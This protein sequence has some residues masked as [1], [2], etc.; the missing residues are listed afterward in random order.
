MTDLKSNN[1]FDSLEAFF[2]ERLKDASFAPPQGPWAQIEEELDLLEKQKRKRRFLWFFMSGLVL[3]CGL[4][5]LWFFVLSDKFTPGS[6]AE[7][8][9][10]AL[11]VEEKKLNEEKNT[12]NT[13]NKNTTTETPGTIKEEKTETPNALAE[14]KATEKTVLSEN[15]PATVISQSNKIQLA[16]CTKKA[17]PAIFNKIPYKVIEVQGNDGYIR[18]FA[19]TSGNKEVALNIIHN[20]GFVKAF[21][22][23]NFNSNDESSVVK[24]EGVI[25]K[26]S[27]IYTATTASLPKIKPVSA[28]EQNSTNVASVKNIAETKTTNAKTEKNTTKTTQPAN[29][30]VVTNSAPVKTENN[31]STPPVNLNN[32]SNNNSAN[33]NAL[34]APS[35]NQNTNNTTPPVAKTEEVK[36]VPSENTTKTDSVPTQ[37]VANE[38]KADSTPVK[39]N[40]VDSVAKPASNYQTPDAFTPEWAILLLAGPNI[41]AQNSQSNL[42]VATNEQQT[43]SVNAEAKIQFKPFK[44]FSFSAGVNYNQLIANQGNPV[45]FVFNKNQ[46]DDYIFYSSHGP[47]A[48]PMSVLLEGYNMGVP[49]D[50]FFAKYT[51][52][53]KLNVISIPLEAN[54]H[55]LNKSKFSL[56]AG[57]GVNT[58]F[59]LSQRTKLTIVKENFNNDIS[60]NNITVNKFNISMLFSLGCDIRLGKRLYL[61]LVPS[62]RYGITN[63][64]ATSGTTFSPAYFSG[65]AGLKFKF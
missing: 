55:F 59:V 12:T 24:N 41:F 4:A 64:S 6:L 48:A 49:F 23:K 25:E 51:Y 14:S 65:N 44:K 2:H 60:Y 31:N 61:T 57:V 63:M 47:I 34:S 62:Y 46:K 45:H 38:T 58:S 52:T 54:F 22:K 36:T 33:N 50:T 30:A 18:Y 20:S 28:P 26:E 32:G 29:E 1:E 42:F 37:V 16:A 19:E 35:Q 15:T 11:P 10:Q 13:S 56:F 40:P 39:T 3:L 17:N 21:V 7:K 43:P 27:G 53:S 8:N 9:K 5:S